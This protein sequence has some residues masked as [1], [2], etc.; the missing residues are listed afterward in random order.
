M[1]RAWLL[2]LIVIAIAVPIAA[3]FLVAGPG[4]GVAVG[5]LVGAILV[6]VVARM[7]PER[8]IEVAAAADHRYRLLVVALVAIEEPDAAASVAQS[9]AVGTD[10][11]VLAPAFNRGL[12]H[13]A[14]D[15]RK[16]REQAQRRLVL[17]LGSLAA[18]GVEARGSVGDADPVQAVEDTL[19]EFAADE[20]IVVAEP[21]EG[22]GAGA[23]TLADLRS[24]LDL[25]LRLIEV[26]PSV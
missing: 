6:F 12:D 10:V 13:W 14:D 19:R 18:A 11:L 17:S 4:L 9:A 25:P 20:A 26:Q 24:R 8:R 1:I 15:L 3:G 5:A 16:A 21:V 23:R 2:P 7:H 22:K